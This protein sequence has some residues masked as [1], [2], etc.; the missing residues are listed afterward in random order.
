MV[1]LIK[2][3][4]TQNLFQ[5][6]DSIQSNLYEVGKCFRLNIHQLKSFCCKWCWNNFKETKSRDKLRIIF[7]SN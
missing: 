3:I 6:H 7:V 1:L 4:Q 2:N 5:L